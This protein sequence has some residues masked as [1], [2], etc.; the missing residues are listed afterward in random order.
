MIDVFAGISDYCRITAPPEHR[1]PIGIVGAGSIVDVAHLPAYRAAGFE[2]AGIFDIDRDRARCTAERHGIGCV[3]ESLEQLLA[4]P[5]VGVV[6][7]AVPSSAQPDI[8]RTVLTSGRHMLGQKPFAPSPQIAIEL[9]DLADRHNLVLAVN[10]QLRYDEGIAAAH[11]M[12]ELGWIGQVT[13]LSITVDIWTDF[14]AWPWLLDTDRLEISNHSIHYHDVV[15]WFL[16]EPASV[17]CLAGR[18]PGQQASGETRTISTY[19][20][21]GGA[22]AVVHANHENRWG[23]NTA[24]FRIDGEH[25]GIRGTLGLLYDYPHGRPDTIELFS[26]VLPTD[27]WLPY[28]VTSRW[29]PDAFAGPM[30]GVFEAIAGGVPPRSTARDNIG[31]LRLVEALYS[32]IATG[33]TQRLETE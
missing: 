5:A 24:T 21:T 28:P 8:A 2:V 22:R 6:D 19:D 16:G 23:D 15:R 4:D 13:A 31:T 11:R 33:A 32:S 26:T 18:R 9:A 7:V 30:A 27:G 17:Y 14:A 20:Y 10:Q 1:L 29:I 12:V 3:Y 25:G